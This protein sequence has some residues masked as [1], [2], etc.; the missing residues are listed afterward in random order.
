MGREHR[1]REVA[2]WRTSPRTPP[3]AAQIV[4]ESVCQLDAQNPR[5]ND[6][7]P[8][9]PRST[10]GRGTAWRARLSRRHISRLVG[11]VLTVPETCGLADRA[12]TGGPWSFP[13]A[14]TQADP[15][16]RAIGLAPHGGSPFASRWRCWPMSSRVPANRRNAAAAK[17]SSRHHGSRL[18]PPCV[19]N[20]RG[21]ASTA[22]GP[23]V[24][25][26]AS[27]GMDVAGMFGPIPLTGRGPSPNRTL[28]PQ[29]TK[30]RQPVL[31]VDTRLWAS[32]GRPLQVVARCCAA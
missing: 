15:R 10:S 30:S 17:T 31:P 27:T 4:T 9:G 26:A 25:S 28:A 2:A 32:G 12:S 16:R 18:A 22:S 1:V 19:Q 21:G 3:P 24:R 8:S 23:T 14:E 11:I 13:R 5:R 6:P 20:C 7:Q 29:A